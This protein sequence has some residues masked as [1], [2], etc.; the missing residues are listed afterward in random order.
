MNE[1]AWNTYRIMAYCL[2]EGEN[3]DWEEEREE[4]GRYG[5]PDKEIAAAKKGKRVR[6]KK[7]HA[8]GFWKGKTNT[9]ATDIEPGMGGLRKAVRTLKKDGRDKARRR[10]AF[11]QVKSGSD[12]PS[13]LRDKDLVAGNT[14]AMMRQALGKKPK[15]HRYSSKSIKGSPTR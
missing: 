3:V 7:K 10:R 11:D 2:L 9:D 6:V 4:F 15:V 12:D 14:R 8:K 13:V 1:S 5:D